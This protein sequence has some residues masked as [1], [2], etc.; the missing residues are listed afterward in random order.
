MAGSFALED[1]ERGRERART[2]QRP[3]KRTVPKTCRKETAADISR[4]LQALNG[5]NVI[6]SGTLVRYSAAHSRSVYSSGA[7]CPIVPPVV[8]AVCRGYSA[9]TSHPRRGSGTDESIEEHN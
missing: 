8:T 7:V 4:V 5:T 2:Q 6:R 9:G 3:C 1:F